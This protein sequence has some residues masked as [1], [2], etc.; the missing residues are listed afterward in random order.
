MPPLPSPN[1]LSKLLVMLLQ[2][3]ISH[4]SAKA[5]PAHEKTSSPS[6]LFPG[7]QEFSLPTSPP[8]SSHLLI[9]GLIC[10]GHPCTR[11]FLQLKPFDPAGKAACITPHSII[12]ETYGFTYGLWLANSGWFKQQHLC[13]RPHSTHHTTFSIS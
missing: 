5:S 2:T 4:Y 13:L 3:F 10:M 6:S 12:S 9:S 8:P 7:F 11:L 1:L